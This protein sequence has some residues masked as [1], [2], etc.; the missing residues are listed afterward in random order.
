[1]ETP[2]G[3]Q[4]PYETAERLKPSGGGASRTLVVALLAIGLLFGYSLGL[5]S[6]SSSGGNT[7]DPTVLYDEKTVTS[8]F[9]DA[10]PAVVQITV[11]LATPAGGLGRPITG[12]GSGFLIDREGHIVTNNHVVD[13][14]ERLTLRLSDGR[15]LAA[16]RLGSSPADDLAVLQVDAEEVSGIDPL[17]LADSSEVRPGQLALA[18]GSPFQNFNSVTAGVVSGTGRGPASVLRRPIPDMIQ[19]DAALNP[20]NSGGPL[21]NSDGEVIGVNSSIRT[22]STAVE[23][24][25]IGFAV[26]SNTLKDLLPQLLRSERVRR[27]WLG[28]SGSSV[29]PELGESLDVPRGVYIAGVFSGSPADEVGLRPFR[30]FTIG[31][32]GD[33]ITAVDGEPVESMEQIVGYFNTQGPG[34]EVILSIYR[35]A[36]IIEVAVTLAEWPD[37]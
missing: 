36:N 5:F 15:T 10:S 19:T 25:R 31:G 34:A 12:S 7:S 2:A 30:A 13:G 33:V 27:P 22:G 32:R 24:F 37:T 1:M 20:G 9:E 28:V 14:A 4:H 8:V 16:T 17:T 3:P 23:D 18:V 11:T 21:L 29:T 6:S 26:P 35:D